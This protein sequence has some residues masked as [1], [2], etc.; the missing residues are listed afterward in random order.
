MSDATFRV[1]DWGRIG[2]DGKGRPLHKVE[3]LASID[4]DAGPV[5]PLVVE[6]ESYS[7]GTREPLARCAYFSLDRYRL[8]GPI[9]LGSADRFTILLGLGGSALVG[10][11]ENQQR[12]D[13]GQTLLLPAALGA[14]EVVPEGEATVLSCVVP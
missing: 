5:N 3:A 2:H 7:W 13:Y 4:F 14:C 12:L 11:P 10:G 9:S 6:P 8:Q 1:F